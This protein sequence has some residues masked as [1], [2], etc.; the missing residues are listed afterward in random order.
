MFLINSFV[1]LYTSFSDH[2][3]AGFRK[4]SPLHWIAWKNNLDEGFTNTTNDSTSLKLFGFSGKIGFW[5][6]EGIEESENSRWRLTIFVA[7]SSFCV[8]VNLLLSYNYYY[9]ITPYRLT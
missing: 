8:V 7:I 3:Y 9:K 6:F 1:L 2:S 5:R 4:N